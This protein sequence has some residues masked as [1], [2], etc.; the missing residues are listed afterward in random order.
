MRVSSCSFNRTEVIY[1]RNMPEAPIGTRLLL[2]TKNRERLSQRERRAP[3]DF[4][5]GPFRRVQRLDG[6]AAGQG[7]RPVGEAQPTRQEPGAER[8][9]GAFP[10]HEDVQEQHEQKRKKILRR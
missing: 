2:G 1:T 4:H 6:P 9:H 7:P 8:G 3:L 5:A 10:A